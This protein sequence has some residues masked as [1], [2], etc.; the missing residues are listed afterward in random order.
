MCSFRVLLCLFCFGENGKRMS[1]LKIDLIKWMCVAMVWT[2]KGDGVATVATV[3]TRECE[4]NKGD[5]IRLLLLA[6]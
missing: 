2:K 5:V 4:W 1:P 3:A 6:R